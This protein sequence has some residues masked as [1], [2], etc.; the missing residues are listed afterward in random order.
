MSD[1][2]MTPWAAGSS[3][4]G[5][6]QARILEWVASSFSR[7]FPN[8][9]TESVSPALVGRLSLG[10]L[11]SCK[12]LAVV[13]HFGYKPT[14]NELT[15]HVV[16]FLVFVTAICELFLFCSHLIKCSDTSPTWTHQECYLS[17][18]LLFIFNKQYWR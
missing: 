18:F 12:I 6:F 5:I 3:V 10:H 2:F 9:G 11:G 8:P 13:N 7:R 17:F 1:S 15:K 16:K 14:I 4:H